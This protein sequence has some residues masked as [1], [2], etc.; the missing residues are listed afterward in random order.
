[1]AT[2]WAM[3]SALSTVMTLPPTSTV[4]AASSGGRREGVTVAAGAGR[5]VAVGGRGSGLVRPQASELASNP[6]AANPVRFR[7]WRRVNEA[8]I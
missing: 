6:P 3:V 2:A 5:A 1:M 4:S 7:N 8:S